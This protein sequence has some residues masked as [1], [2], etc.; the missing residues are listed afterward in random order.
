MNNHH[1]PPDSCYRNPA[2]TRQ[3]NSVGECCCWCRGP[4][5]CGK[6]EPDSRDAAR[7][8]DK[9][10]YQL[11]NDDEELE[12][13]LP[14]R[15]EDELQRD[16]FFRLPYYYMHNYGLHH[17]L[18]FSYYQS[19]E[20]GRHHLYPV[21]SHRSAPCQDVQH[22]VDTQNCQRENQ[23]RHHERLEDSV[24]P[25]G[26]S[27]NVPQFS[28]PH[29]ESMSQVGVMNLSSAGGETFVS[30]SHEK[31]RTIRLPD[32]QRNIFITCSSDVALEMISFMD[33]LTKHG[34]HP[35]IDMFDNSVRCMDI[36]KWKDS[37]LNNPSNL[38]I[39]AISPKYKA[40]I[41]G[42]VVDNQGLHTKYIHSMMQNEFIQQ[43]SLNFRFI[44]VLFISASQKHVPRWLQN[45]CVYQW[46]QDAE[47]LLLRLLRDER[48][49][50]PTVPVELTLMIKPVALS[51]AAT[52]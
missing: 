43:G 40:D 11:Q 47:D 20:D 27:V 51:S 29:V 12:A 34:F 10:I 49:V 15:S 44:P 30:H 14:L 16:T 28:I 35:A 42:S 6:A 37:Y 32:E 31:R 1:Q 48:Y 41:E 50:P 23:L 5:G 52:L 8:E 17:T 18:D 4:N 2:K 13:P 45:T 24:A 21:S 25:G 36:N 9:H 7:D 19:A 33:F 22:W 46:P 39:V 38:I 26:V 3:S